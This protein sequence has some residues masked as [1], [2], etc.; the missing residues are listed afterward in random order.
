MLRRLGRRAAW[1]ADLYRAAR[2]ALALC[3]VLTAIFPGRLRAV[4][5]PKFSEPDVN[6]Y[7]E[8]LGHF[9]DH[10]VAVARAARHGDKKQLKKMEAEIPQWQEK[11][12]VLLDQLQPGETKPFTEYVSLCGLTMMDAAFGM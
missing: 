2:T 11:A 10:Y 6:A 5:P 8:A 7:V 4:P 9:R 12:I 3:V 1:R